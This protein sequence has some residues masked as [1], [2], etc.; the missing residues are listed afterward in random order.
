MSKLSYYKLGLNSELVLVVWYGWYNWYSVCV[1]QFEA[2]VV[3][4]VNGTLYIKNEIYMKVHGNL[5][6]LKYYSPYRLNL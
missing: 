2:I 6:F 3:V 4:I 1:L 5:G